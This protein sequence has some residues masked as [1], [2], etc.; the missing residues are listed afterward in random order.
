MS[1]ADYRSALAEGAGA[2]LVGAP[3]ASPWDPS[4]AEELAAQD[5]AVMEERLLPLLLADLTSPGRR[6]PG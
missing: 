5:S 4:L 6:A 1:A 2:P 3:A